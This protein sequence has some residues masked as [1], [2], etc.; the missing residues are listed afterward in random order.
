MYRTVA[1]LW[2]TS[3]YAS[4]RC[5]VE[6]RHRLVEDDQ[7]GIGCERA[8]ERDALPLA[9]RELVRIA[10]GGVRGQP[11]L[12]EDLGDAAPYLSP[13]HALVHDERFG[14]R[15]AHAETRVQR[16]PGVLEHGLYPR[17]IRA[18]RSAGEGMHV[19]TVEQ[20]AAGRR[21]LEA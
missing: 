19:L 5:S 4:F 8:R 18:E 17:A 9:P 13:G 16:R 14:D 10:A 11:D 6:R 2:A 15:V 12:L 3:R 1:R 20:H 7:L 21:P